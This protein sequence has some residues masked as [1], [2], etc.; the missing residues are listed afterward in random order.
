VAQKPYSNSCKFTLKT[1]SR[2]VG[3]TLAL[4]HLILSQKMTHATFDFRGTKFR[5]FRALYHPLRHC[6]WG[7]FERHLRYLCTMIRQTIFV[8]AS[9]LLLAQ[10]V[11][12][13][14]LKQVWDYHLHQPRDRN[15]LFAMAVTP[16]QDVLSL[17]ATANGTSKLSRIRHSLE[18]NPNEQTIEVPG[19]SLKEGSVTRDGKYV[20]CAAWGLKKGDAGWVQIVPVVDLP[21]FKLVQTTTVSDLPDYW[22][23]VATVRLDDRQVPFHA[24]AEQ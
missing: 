20:V 14:E 11:D 2:L 19:I 13:A 23:N 15:V 4:N 17:L 22:H 5:S 21:V 6:G 18:A 16:D 12:G 10:C 7:I 1:L 9:L 8:F 24:A 3:G